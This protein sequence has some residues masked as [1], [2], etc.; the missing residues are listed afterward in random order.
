MRTS[1]MLDV[2]GSPA[3]SRSAPGRAALSGIMLAGCAVFAAAAQF[4]APAVE[5]TS[6]VVDPDLARLMQGMA[7]IKLALVALMAGLLVWRFGRPMT[8]PVTLGYLACIWTVTAATVLIWQSSW[9]GLASVLF[10]GAGFAFMVI[11]LKD[12]RV[13]PAGLRARAQR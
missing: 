5:I 1:S 3:H 6:A 10:H 11:G 8:A 7:F 2:A 12:D 9:L 4:L 13:L